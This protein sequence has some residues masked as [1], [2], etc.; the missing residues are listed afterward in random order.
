[1]N[2]QTLSILLMTL[3]GVWL[4]AS[5]VVSMI[6]P[7][8]AHKLVA[9]RP[10]QRAWLLRLIA[11]T[12]TLF[13]LL[14]CTELFALP[15]ELV[16]LHC[17]LSN[18][19]PHHPDPQLSLTTMAS[20]LLVVLTPV[21]LLALNV[22]WSTATL[23]RRWR[24]LSRPAGAYRY[25]DI[26]QQVA[27]IVGLW[28]PTIYFSRGFIA[29][30]SPT[31]LQVVVAHE[32]AHAARYDNLWTALVRIF[33]LGWVSRQRLTADLELAQEQACDRHAALSI[34]DAATVA[35]TLVQ[36]QRLV[37]TPQVACAFLRG[38]LSA[39]VNMLLDPHYTE[40]SPLAVLRIA[41]LA[42]MLATVSVI[43]LHYLVEFV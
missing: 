12:P 23:E 41:C 26:S 7:L 2:L 37:Q 20:L 36:C 4:A 13:A 10:A 43:P 32:Q 21:V 31:T 30:L 27:C 29:Q 14:A 39:R 42:A 8:Y 24:R 19:A 3:A 18:C 34:G 11:L 15:E 1:M 40:L 25:L 22:L 28:R 6:Y 35:E 5:L 17:H 33:S 38:Q 16:P 9:I